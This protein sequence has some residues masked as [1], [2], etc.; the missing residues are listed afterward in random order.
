M[1][2]PKLDRDPMARA[3]MRSLSRDD[4]RTLPRNADYTA[5]NALISAG[6]IEATT[7]GFQR[8]YRLTTKAKL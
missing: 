1:A 5:L 2:A 6:W 4:F 8:S 3:I 7:N